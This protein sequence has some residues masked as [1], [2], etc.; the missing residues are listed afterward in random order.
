MKRLCNY[1]IYSS[2]L[3]RSFWV[4]EFKFCR[5]NVIIVNVFQKRKYR[6]LFCCRVS[7]LECVR[8][9]SILLLLA[10]TSCSQRVSATK[11]RGKAY[12]CKQDVRGIPKMIFMENVTFLLPFLFNTYHLLEFSIKNQQLLFQKWKT[13]LKIQVHLNIKF[14]RY[15][16]K[17][18]TCKNLSKENVKKIEG[19][20]LKV[21]GYNKVWPWMVS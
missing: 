6:S 20:Q 7:K 19:F 5:K 15:W 14:D 12:F 8:W 18:I 21:A 11:K 17:K 1:E 16:T 2:F 4:I 9:I 13:K 3:F 10:L